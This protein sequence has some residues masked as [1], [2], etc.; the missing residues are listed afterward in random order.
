MVD[1]RKEAATK[2]V[3]SGSLEPKAKGI[4]VGHPL[5]E[6]LEV[7][8]DHT[9]FNTRCSISRIAELI[10]LYQPRVLVLEDYDGKGSRRCT[11]VE[12]LI[13]DIS[14]LAL[15]KNVKVRRSS[16]AWIKRRLLNQ[17]E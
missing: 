9:G 2:N 1:F 11:R 5:G 3:S 17:A 12:K 6:N 14:K 13:D 8:N 16:R 15:K 10:E 7:F 4:D